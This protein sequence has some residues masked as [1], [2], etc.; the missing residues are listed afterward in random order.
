MA[1]NVAWLRNIL[2]QNWGLKLLATFLAILTYYAIRGATRYEVEYSI[3]VDVEV[4]PGIAVLAKNPDQVDVRLR[5]SQD[6]L[7][8]LDQK[9][10]KARVSV[11]DETLGGRPQSVTIAPRDIVGARGVSVVMIEP[12]EVMITFDH[13]FETTFSVAKPETIG[14]PLL[15]NVEVQYSPQ[16]VTIRGPKTRIAELKA[17]GHDQVIAD[18][19]DVDGRVESFSKRVAV[20]SPGGDWASKIDPEEITVQVNIIKKSVTRS[21]ESL[22]VRAIRGAEASGPVVIDPPVVDVTLEGRSE[23]LEN[24]SERDIRIFVDCYRVDPA[25][26]N[27]LPVQ[28]H[29]PVFMD[30]TMTVVPKVVRVGFP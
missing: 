11:R 21:W 5:G 13:E 24:V 30:V 26:T 2:R 17:G 22:P 7:L 4:S 18:P 14:E 12:P 28:V 29:L 20:H 15:G 6:D 23:L 3:P 1:P 27:E 25:V 9:L 8:N 16:T 10:L 19:V